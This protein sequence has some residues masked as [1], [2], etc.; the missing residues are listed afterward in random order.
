MD[1]GNISSWETARGRTTTTGELV[2]SSKVLTSVLW[3]CADFN[4][5][6]GWAAAGMLRVLGTIQKSQHSTALINEQA[7]LQTWVDEILTSAWKYQVGRVVLSS[8]RYGMRHPNSSGTSEVAPRRSQTD[9][10]VLQGYIHSSA[11]FKCSLPR[12]FNCSL[13]Q[14]CR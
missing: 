1:F 11:A 10:D 5:G 14:R 8:S 2:R 7:N 3:G 13:S 12:H 4:T 6:N 9:Y